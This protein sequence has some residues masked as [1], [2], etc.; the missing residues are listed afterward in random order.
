MKSHF[1][2]TGSL[3]L[4]VLSSCKKSEPLNEQPAE[5]KWVVSTIAGDGTAAFADGPA[6]S[7]KFHFP[8]DV[9]VTNDGTIYVTDGDNSRIRKIAGGQVYGFAGDR[10]GIANGNGP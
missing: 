5:K 9:V 4:L 2:L 7:A 3:L 8:E 10:F 6:L 1:M